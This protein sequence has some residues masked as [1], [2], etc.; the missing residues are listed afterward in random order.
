MHSIE[1]LSEFEEI[2]NY[3]FRDKGLLVTALTHPSY[4]TQNEGNSNNYQRLEFL[5]DAVLSFIITDELFKLYPMEREGKLACYRSALIQG[6]GL[7]NF[8]RKIRLPDFVFLS[9]AESK[10]GGMNKDSILEDVFEGLIGAIYLDSNIDCIRNFI[11]YIF[12]D[13]ERVLEEM[14]PSLNPK[15]RL[16]EIVQQKSSTGVQYVLLASSGPDHNKYFSVNVVIQG[17]VLGSGSGS[18]KKIA[19][20][21][22]AIR[23]LEYLKTH[24]IFKNK[25]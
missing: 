11:K 21:E 10:M 3:H 17:E 9:E 14:L 15:G 18:S 20:E 16:Q 2:I 1:K 7:A 8:A 23:A 25:P 5:G 19:E 24:S 22:A 6:T 12:C 4:N 13:I